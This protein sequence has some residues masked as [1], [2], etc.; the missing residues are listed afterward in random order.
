MPATVTVKM[1]KEEVSSLLDTLE[2]R[3]QSNS[4]RHAGI[5]WEDVK[6]RLSN[7]PEKIAALQAMENSGG[8]PDV[9]DLDKQNGEFIFYDCAAESPKGRRSLCYDQEA[10]ES[11]KKFKPEDS[12]LRLAHSW[13]AQLLDESQ[14]QHLQ[15]LGEFDLKTSSWLLTPEPVRKLGGAI[16]GDRR[17]GRVFIYHNGAESYYGA[18]GFRCVVSV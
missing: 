9:V 14:Y 12:A 8:E 18:R 13:G 3:F 7:Q 6:A 16:F 4:G 10:L 15:Q 5:A 17:F 1:T 2:K 11:R